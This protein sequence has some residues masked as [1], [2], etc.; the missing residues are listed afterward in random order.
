MTTKAD[1]PADEW[2]R[3]VR[4][5][6]VA[7]LAIT[8]ADPGGPIEATKET[9]GTLKAA[10]N[11]PSR[12]QLL[13]EVALE[14]QALAQ[15]KQHPL[16]GYKPSKKSPVGEQVLDELRAVRGIVEAK[17]TPEEAE[18]FKQWLVATAQAA[19][20]AAKDGGFMGIGAHLVSDREQAMLDQVRRAVLE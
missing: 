17:A 18:A 6:F 19:A 15:Q 9:M 2:S 7:G 16:K 3:V 11:P 12:E 5:P 13:A 10:T 1:F 14:V 20:G 8:L 4:A